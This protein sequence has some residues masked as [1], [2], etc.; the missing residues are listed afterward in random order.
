MSSTRLSGHG[1]RSEGK[2]FSADGKRLTTWG[3]QVGHAKCECGE[4]SPVLNSNA[5][6]KHWHWQHKEDHR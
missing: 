1:L 5:A 2:P 3:A 6:R 4:L